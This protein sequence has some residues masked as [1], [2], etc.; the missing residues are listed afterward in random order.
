MLQ[1]V[2]HTFTEK[3]KAT[4]KG[5]EDHG[6]L[7]NRQT[8]EGLGGKASIAP[9]APR[10]IGPTISRPL[11]SV[12][13]ALVRTQG[14]FQSD[15]AKTPESQTP[16]ARMDQKGPQKHS[17]FAGVLQKQVNIPS[18]KPIKA[19]RCRNASRKLGTNFLHPSPSRVP[20]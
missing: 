9:H 2:I 18:N 17:H 5:E 14:L 19:S 8:P 11:T 4:K 10:N 12:P 13:S 15:T 7:Y 3:L 6:L 20:G 1:Y 16:L